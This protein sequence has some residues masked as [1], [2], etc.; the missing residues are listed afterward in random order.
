MIKK[1][2]FFNDKKQ[3]LRGFVHTPK[4]KNKNKSKKSSR[5]SKL[6][7]AAQHE[8]AIIFLHGFPSCCYGSTAKRAARDFSKRSYLVMM[9]DFSGTNKSEGKFEDKLISQEVRE[10]RYAIDFLE[11]E[12]GF[13]KLVLV[14]HSTGGID[15]ALYAHKDKRISKLILFGASGNLKES[16]KYEFTQLQI[17]Q[18]W[19]KG[20]ITYKQEGKW[21]HNK[22]MKKKY[23]DEFFKLDVLKS[24]SKFRKPVLIVHGSDDEAVPAEVDAK[25]LYKAA[26]MPKK[27]LIVNG[28]DHRFSR[29]MHWDRFVREADRFIQKG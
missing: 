8:T 29:K 2:Y 4:Y 12:F 18:F 5:A 14:G 15:A 23:Y 28:A 13:K 9:F 27:L 24:L 22:K 19:I 1:I 7:N 20:F 3:K 16:V 6:N 26:R 25:D 10:I 21:F 17:R 11:K